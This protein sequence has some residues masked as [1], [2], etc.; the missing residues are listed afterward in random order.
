VDNIGTRFKTACH[1][2]LL[3]RNIIERLMR[4]RD[5]IRW[6]LSDEQP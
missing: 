1:L 6:R 2:R 5:Q 4:H 3:A